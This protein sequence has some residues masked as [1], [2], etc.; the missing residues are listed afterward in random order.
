MAKG[1]SS[2]A[3]AEELGR[4]GMLGFFGAAGL[5]LSRWKRPPIA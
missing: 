5:P 3:M 4:A 2:A 1:I